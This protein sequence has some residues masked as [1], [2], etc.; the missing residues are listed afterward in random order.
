MASRP[1]LVER[2]GFGA[3]P[4][5]NA[6]SDPSPPGSQGGQALVASPLSMVPQGAPNDVRD[7]P[8]R[9]VSSDRIDLIRRVVGVSAV[10]DQDKLLAIVDAMDAV[11]QQTTRV[12]NASV[13]VERE[14]GLALGKLSP[15]EGQGGQG[16]RGA[17]SR[18]VGQQRRKTRGG[19]Q[20]LRLER[21]AAVG[22]AG[23]V[24]GPLRA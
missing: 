18:L 6:S 7:R 14:I 3:V 21:R 13:I 4:A 5:A 19:R 1:R 8:L 11:S 10:E 24:L 20:V 2:T 12:L 23:D 15:G 9:V 16:V 17:V 22:A